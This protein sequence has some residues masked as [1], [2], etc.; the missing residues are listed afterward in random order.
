MAGANNKCYFSKKLAKLRVTTNYEV[1]FNAGGFRKVH[2]Q[3]VERQEGLSFLAVQKIDFDLRTQKKAAST[4]S[5]IISNGA[6]ECS[7]LQKFATEIIFLLPQPLSYFFARMII[8]AVMA[9]AWSQARPISQYPNYLMTLLFFSYFLASARS[10]IFVFRA[11][12]CYFTFHLFP[13][14]H[15]CIPRAPRALDCCFQHRVIMNN[16]YL[17]LN[18]PSLLLLISLL[19]APSLTLKLSQ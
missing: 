19:K 15:F 16:F 4:H 7:L 13:S 12:T 8:F 3:M 5:V 10:F 14:D 9:L 6:N 18:F 17:R 11:C 2:D 1:F